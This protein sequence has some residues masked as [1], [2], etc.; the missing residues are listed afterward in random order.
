MARED[1][2][3]VYTDQLPLM[4]VATIPDIDLEIARQMVLLGKEGVGT[5]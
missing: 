1:A 5:T 3:F 2:T 4:V